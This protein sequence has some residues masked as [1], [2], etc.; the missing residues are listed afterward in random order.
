MFNPLTF[1]FKLISELAVFI[2][3]LFAIISFGLI[4][5]SPEKDFRL[6]A[7]YSLDSMKGIRF[8]FRKNCA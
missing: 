7:S 1:A 4:P 8:S 6:N 2:I 3:K 5:N